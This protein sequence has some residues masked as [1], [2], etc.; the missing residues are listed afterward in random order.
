MNLD[1]MA[2]T[3]DDTEEE[4]ERDRIDVE[5]DGQA[6]AHRVAWTDDEDSDG[7]YKKFKNR[8]RRAQRPAKPNSTRASASGAV[9]ADDREGRHKRRRTEQPSRTARRDTHHESDSEDPFMPRYLRERKT[10]FETDHE[11]LQAASL[12][13]PPS[14]DEVEFSDDERLAHLKER[15]AFAQTKPMQPYRDRDLP[16]SLGT[17]PAPV[18]QWLRDYQLEGVAFLHRLFVYQTGGILGD[19]MGLGKTVQVIAFLTAAFGKTGDERDRKRMRK[20]RRAGADWY[21]RV[22]IVCPGTLIENVSK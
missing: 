7:V 16:Y 5:E 6:A 2:D 19:D 4:E 22:L 11:R 3:L 12:R 21:P 10:K 17:I 13:L 15:P 18:A 1:T 14:Y 9:P 20:V 8:K